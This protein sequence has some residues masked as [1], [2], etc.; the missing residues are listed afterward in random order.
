VEGVAEVG[1]EALSRKG[2][3]RGAEAGP[4]LRSMLTASQG[5]DRDPELQTGT[6]KI[7]TTLHTINSEYL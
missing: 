2:E 7:I 5:P 1:A 6:L 4:H 3:T